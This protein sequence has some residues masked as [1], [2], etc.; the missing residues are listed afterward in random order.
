MIIPVWLQN[1][2]ISAGLE[3]FIGHTETTCIAS[4]Y[5]FYTNIKIKI[6]RSISTE[7]YN[8]LYAAINNYDGF[9]IICIACE[10]E[11]T[12]GEFIHP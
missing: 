7:I 4:Y 11:V 6:I 9:L 10:R 1:R 8:T 2:L 3:P 12:P 5:N